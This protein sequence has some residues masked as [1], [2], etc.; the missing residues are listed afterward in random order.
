MEPAWLYGKMIFK[1]KGWDCKMNFKKNLYALILSLSILGPS[2]A[3]ANQSDHA[4]SVA[5]A[6]IPIGASPSTVSETLSK[7]APRPVLIS[8]TPEAMQFSNGFFFLKPARNWL[9]LFNNGKLYEASVEIPVADSERSK[10]IQDLKAL[11]LQRYGLP[12]DMKWET[13]NTLYGEENFIG[14]QMGGVLYTINIINTP[15]TDLKVSYR[16]ESTY[17]KMVNGNGQ[18]SK[19]SDDL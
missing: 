10:L 6:G 12:Q 4:A 19:G 18:T 15:G 7:R 11:V 17:S 3:F 8:N 14:M 9:F 2:V 16:E 5:F 1:R 13:S